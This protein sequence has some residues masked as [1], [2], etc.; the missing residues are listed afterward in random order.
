VVPFTDI[1][2]G[3]FSYTIAAGSPQETTT[4][5]VGGVADPGSHFWEIIVT[6]HNAQTD[7]PAP[8]SQFWQLDGGAPGFSPVEDY[9]HLAYLTP[10]G[11]SVQQLQAANAMTDTIPPGGTTPVIFLSEGTYLDSSSP[12]Q[13]TWDLTSL[14]HVLAQ[15]SLP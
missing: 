1:T 13:L 3:G 8:M 4:S 15:L 14:N 11:E 7:R 10:Y 9:A 6:I 2:T 12:S 5:K